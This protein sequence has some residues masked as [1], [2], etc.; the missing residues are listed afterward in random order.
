M[1]NLKNVCQKCFG[2]C[3]CLGNRK[4]ERKEEEEKKT[5]EEKTLNNKNGEELK[6]EN[7]NHFQISKEIVKQIKDFNHKKLTSKQKSL[8]EQLIPKQELK[9]RYNKFGLCQEC[10]QPNTG[11]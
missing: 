3:S 9:E 6:E 5:K 11:T 2:D 8:I 1:K 4:K 10:N 7:I